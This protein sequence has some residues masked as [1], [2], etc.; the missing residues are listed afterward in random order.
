MYT[1]KRAVG[2]RLVSPRGQEFVDIS[3]MSLGE[4]PV[5]FNRL[6]IVI[7][8]ELADKEVSL[9]LDDYRNE[10]SSSKLFIQEWLDTKADTPLK[11]SNYI[12]SN[13]EAY[14]TS[15]DIQY[16][17]FSLLPGNAAM[18]EDVQDELT[19]SGARDIRVRKTNRDN[20]DYKQLNDKVL[21]TINGHLTR[22]VV[23]EDS[24]YLLNAGKHFRIHDN[25][26]VGCLNFN[27]LC[28]VKTVGIKPE[29]IR[30]V[31]EHDVIRVHYKSKESF[32]DK[33]V[34]MS[35]GG[36]LYMNDVVFISG[37]STITIKVQG[38]DWVNALFDSK[39]LIDLSTVIDK[40]RGVI[41]P[42]EIKTEEFFKT[43]LTDLS[44]F[45]I[46][47]DDPYIHVERKP[48]T[49]YRYPFTYHT[50]ETRPLP[51]LT[52]DGLLPKYFIR[53]II[54]RRLLDIDLPIQR[55]YLGKTTGVGNEGNLHHNLTN[56]YEPSYYR[57]GYLLYIR[58]LAK[59]SP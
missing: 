53:Q 25:V 58:A 45:L 28:N 33:T 1:Y 54:N 41:R 31:K 47:L 37:P 6:V 17:W 20:F 14:V 36:R 11:T 56:R 42:E 30:V 49:V 39:E 15:H 26:H 46:I 7:K 48:I 59:G 9:N 38:V 18:G 13:R 40:D 22:G 43:L 5:I 44:S 21:W 4:L 57:T 35:I 2:V 27:T 10:F 34:W 8:D 50:H 51:L 23:G 32:N 19:V 52:G 24:V 29:D 12:P 16:E 3:G 55:K